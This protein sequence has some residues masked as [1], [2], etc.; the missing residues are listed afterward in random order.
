[1]SQSESSTLTAK[2]PCGRP[3]RD[4]R[5]PSLEEMKTM[6][7]DLSR[8]YKLSEKYRSYHDFFMISKNVL[9]ALGYVDNFI[10]FLSK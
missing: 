10:E 5:F 1:M 2:S 6:R 8:C 7:Q 9:I 3:V 4:E